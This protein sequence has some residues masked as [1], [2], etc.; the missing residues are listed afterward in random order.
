MHIIFNTNRFLYLLWSHER[1]QHVKVCWWTLSSLRWNVVISFQDKEVEGQGSRSTETEV[2]CGKT[3][4]GYVPKTTNS[5]NVSAF[6]CMS[7][8]AENLKLLGWKNPNLTD[9]WP[10]RPSYASL[11]VSSWTLTTCFRPDHVAG[12]CD[13]HYQESSHQGHQTHASVMQTWN[14]SFTLSLYWAQT[15]P[16]ATCKGLCQ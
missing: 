10:H 8:F 11:N 5:P 2:P 15:W 1:L 12:M 16:N 6:V 9:T 14:P 3:R 7:V 13:G 4:Q